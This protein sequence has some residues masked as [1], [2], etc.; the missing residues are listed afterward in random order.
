M[1]EIGAIGSY[2]LTLQQ[3]QLSIIKQN[4]EMQQQVAEI[5]LDSERT[6]PGSSDK[7]TTID[8]NI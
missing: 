3:L 7:G 2:A 5:L 1:N 4:A 6:A 8:I